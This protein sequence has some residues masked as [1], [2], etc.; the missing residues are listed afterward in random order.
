M[1]EIAPFYQYPKLDLAAALDGLQNFIINFWIRGKGY[2]FCQETFENEKKIIKVIASSKL[3]QSESNKKQTNDFF[4]CFFE[5]LWN[6]LDELKSINQLIKQEF[7][8][9]K[10]LC[11][12]NKFLNT[13]KIKDV[14]CDAFCWQ[15]L[16]FERKKELAVILKYLLL[17]K[18]NLAISILKIFLLKLKIKILKKFY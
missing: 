2:K 6:H 13:R 1:L 12:I 9:I 7:L 17:N 4:V 16:K 8:F 11:E 10:E 3:F 15:I 18:G 5:V 14:F